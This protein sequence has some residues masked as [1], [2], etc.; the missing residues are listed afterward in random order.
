MARIARVP[1][2]GL[3]ETAVK[4]RLAAIHVGAPADIVDGLRREERVLAHK[5]A[6]RL[7]HLATR[8]GKSVECAKCGRSGFVGDELIGA[9]HKEPCQ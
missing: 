9:I 6:T 8:Q 3:F 1:E 2:H 4:A 5:V 7:G